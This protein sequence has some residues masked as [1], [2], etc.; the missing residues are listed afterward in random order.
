MSSA[1]AAA[2]ASVATTADAPRAKPVAT[3]EPHLKL[4]RDLESQKPSATREALLKRAHAGE[5]HCDVSDSM[6]P[7]LDLTAALKAAGYVD[8][9]KKLDEYDNDVHITQDD[10]DALSGLWNHRG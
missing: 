6:T 1:P 3:D 9:L 2:A 8:M 5:F 10:I 4:I 7:K